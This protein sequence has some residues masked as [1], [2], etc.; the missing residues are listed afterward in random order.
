MR[1]TKDDDGRIN[2]FAVEP[3]IYSA[4]PPTPQEKRNYII[5]GVVA[6]VLVTGLIVIA[7]VV[8]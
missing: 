1:Y 8:S 2:N 3:K 6:A 7:T 4:E 5:L